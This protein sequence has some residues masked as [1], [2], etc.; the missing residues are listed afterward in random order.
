MLPVWLCCF[1][2]LGSTNQKFKKDLIM[3][4]YSHKHLFYP[5]FFG[6]TL[7]RPL[8]RTT[9]SATG[10]SIEKRL[11]PDGIAHVKIEKWIGPGSRR[12]CFF[13]AQNAVA[14]QVRVFCV[15][16]DAHSL[17]VFVCVC[18]SLCLFVSLCVFFVFLCVFFVFL[19][20]FFVSLCVFFVFLC[21]FF[22]SLC[23]SLCLFVSP[24]F[25]VSF[26]C[27]LVNVQSIVFMCMDLLRC[28]L[29]W[30]T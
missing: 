14:H 2:L 10:E 5:F 6:V 22:V 29:F 27:V 19:C 9:F 20:V 23:V 12:K 8:H 30:F 13:A 28:C 16:V 18:V 24:C 1:Q 4:S 26:E 15:L 7:P 17:F 21:V 11:R 25:C 3:Q